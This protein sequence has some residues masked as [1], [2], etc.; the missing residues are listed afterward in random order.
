MLT[1]GWVY[2]RQTVDNKEGTGLY[3]MKNS[4]VHC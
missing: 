3:L 2:G 4:F 1:R